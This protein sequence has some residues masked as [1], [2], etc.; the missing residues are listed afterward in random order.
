MKVLFM[1]PDFICIGEQRCGTTWLA[2]N[3][4]QHPQIWLPPFKS[5]RYFNTPSL[6]PNILLMWMFAKRAERR[7]SKG[8]L[9]GEFS[10]SNFTWYLHYY[11]KPRTLSWYRDLFQP[12]ANQIAGEICHAYSG[13]PPKMIAQIYRDFPQ[14]KIIYLVRNP[15][16]R[17]WSALALR[18]HRQDRYLSAEISVEQFNDFLK[19]SNILEKSDYA[20]T[21]EHWRQVFPPDQMFVG[22]FEELVTQPAALLSNIAEFLG[23]DSLYTFDLASLNTRIASTSYDPIPPNRRDMLGQ[24][25]APSIQRLHRQLNSPYTAAWLDE[26]GADGDSIR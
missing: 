9:R 8:F 12:Q 19:D 21:L 16:D 26:L 14:L 2:H 5:I 7:R 1:S 4:K 23:I 18:R 17:A 10:K 15:L 11:L 13:L 24:L 22:F 3:L 6:L 25:L 20:T